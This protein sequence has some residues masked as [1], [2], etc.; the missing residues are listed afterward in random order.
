MS[1]AL[2]EEVR[3]GVGLNFTFI[4]LKKKSTRFDDPGF[5]FDFPLLLDA[6]IGSVISSCSSHSNNKIVTHWCQMNRKQVLRGTVT[7]NATDD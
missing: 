7:T 6:E 5:L 3:V 1:L 4:M 2:T